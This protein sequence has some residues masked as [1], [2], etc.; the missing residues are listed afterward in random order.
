MSL[1]CNDIYSSF[2]TGRNNSSRP[3]T[4]NGVDIVIKMNMRNQNKFILILLIHF[5]FVQLVYSQNNAVIITDSIQKVQLDKPDCDTLV[6]ITS[7]RIKDIN[8]IYQ[9][10]FLNPSPKTR[11]DSLVKK[12]T[13]IEGSEV[14]SSFFYIN[15][16]FDSIG[17]LRSK[18]SVA[19]LYVLSE[20]YFVENSP[21]RYG[22]LG[23]GTSLEVL[24]KHYL[25]N[26]GNTASL[27]GLLVDIREKINRNPIRYYY[28]IPENPHKKYIRLRIDI[29]TKKYDNE[30]ISIINKHSDLRKF[31]GILED[32]KALDTI[33]KEVKNL[34]FTTDAYFDFCQTKLSIYPGSATLGVM[35]SV[36]GKSIEKCYDIQVGDFWQSKKDLRKNG[37]KNLDKLIYKKNYINKGFIEQ[38]RELCNPIPKREDL[39]KV[40]YDKA[41][42]IVFKDTIHNVVVDSVSHNLGEITTQHYE[43]T[44]YFKYIGNDTIRLSNNINDSPIL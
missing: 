11:L 2:L 9:L 33:L 32:R 3:R 25:N 14:F 42:E 35:L 43:I 44:K 19:L 22:S 28:C 29:D 13:D 24:N 21:L 1:L 18:E 12:I 34:E 20:A 17:Q 37:V 4:K 6:L 23:N 40:K 10:Q 39:W 16:L 8:S 30:I 27:Y 26:T 15:S 7:E 31:G 36:D 5:C 38:Q 41:R